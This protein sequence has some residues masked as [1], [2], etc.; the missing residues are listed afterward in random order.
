M[1]TI[2]KNCNVD[3]FMT[4]ASF[5]GIIYHNGNIILSVNGSGAGIVSK[6]NLSVKAGDNIRVLRAEN[7][8]A[9]RPIWAT[10]VFT[11]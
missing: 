1:L 9:W 6:T 4:S 2:N 7:A 5:P 8:D 10:L 11:N 3:I